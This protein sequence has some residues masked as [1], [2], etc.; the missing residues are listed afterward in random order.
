MAEYDTIYFTFINPNYLLL[1]VNYK[2]NV[3]NFVTILVI[4]VLFNF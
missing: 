3:M 2:V 4:Y 1:F